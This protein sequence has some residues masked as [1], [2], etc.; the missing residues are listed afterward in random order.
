MIEGR[1]LKDVF[2]NST[3]EAACEV[4]RSD[5][6]PVNVGYLLEDPEHIIYWCRL[7]IN[8]WHDFMKEFWV[9]GTMDRCP[10]TDHVTFLIGEFCN[11]QVISLSPFV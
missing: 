2:M 5:Q 7:R 10:P 1:R 11:L 3:L 6:Q 9:F 4:L 8:G